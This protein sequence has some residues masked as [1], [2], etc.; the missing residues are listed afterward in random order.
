MYV[1]DEKLRE[2]ATNRQWELLTALEK[3][4]SERKAADALG[5]HKVRFNQVK[6]AVEKKAAMHGYA[7]DHDWRNPVPPGYKVKGT[8]ILRDAQTGE[9][10]LIWEKSEADKAAQ[11]EARQAVLKAMLEEIP[12]PEPIKRA[13]NEPAVN[14]LNQY[15][16]TDFHLGQL[17]WGEECGADYDT[18]IAEKLLVDWFAA[19][20]RQAPHAEVGL[21][22]QLGDFLHWDGMGG[23]VTPTSGFHLDVDTRFQNLVR[24]AVRALRQV[25]NM[26][27]VK[28]P[29]V[30]IIMADAN[31]DPTSG[32]WL[33]E[34]LAAMYADEPTVTVDTSPDTYYC[35]PWGDTSLFYHHGHKKPVKGVADVLAA[36]FREVWGNSKHSYAHTGHLHHLKVDEGNLMVVEQHRT[37]AAADAYASRGGWM[38]GRAAS[39]ITYHKDFGEVG[40]VTLT[41]EMV[42]K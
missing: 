37:L 22:C 39:V 32:V 4:G 13:K 7:P 35:Y 34:M 40:R 24:V 19:A 23:A 30:H 16:I 8:S 11:E 21:L 27:R 26:M 2:Y 5:V 1:L 41:P 17:A 38:S 10:R 12:K 15:T 6:R 25:I 36:K 3:H 28:Y 33:R 9:A 42:S 14:L 31:H 20:I 18:K 29:H